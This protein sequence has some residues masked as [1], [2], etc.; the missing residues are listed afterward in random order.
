MLSSS[1]GRMTTP[2]V[3]SGP[4]D[5]IALVPTILR[6]EPEESVVVMTF[7]P[8]GRSF[9]ARVELPRRPREQ[10][11]VAET[12]LKAIK[13]NHLRE[14]AVVIYSED[15]AVAAAQGRKLNRKLRRAGVRV[16]DV[17]LVS[18][19][20]Y[21]RVLR[22][23]QE[24]TAFDISSH[25]ITA[26]R[27]LDGVV[28]H[29]SR[30]D[31]AA[32]LD[33]DPDDEARRTEVMEAAQRWARNEHDAAAEAQWIRRT[34]TDA[35]LAGEVLEDDL[36]RLLADLLDPDLVD[37]A[38]AVI[39]RPDAGAHVEMWRDLVRRAPDGY[40]D[41]PA[42]L[43]AF[44]AWLTGD[45][46]LAWCGL[47]RCGSTSLAMAD[48]LEQLMHSAVS[49]RLWPRLTADELTALRRPAA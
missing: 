29:R 25:P 44:A 31:L 40:V 19:D 47:E 36:P 3:A 34:L 6:F 33:P 17:L 32:T 39:D 43:L 42:C 22:G 26:Q 1:L 12:I 9:H 24:G 10:D 45:G 20:R 7:G 18:R 48:M 30:G 8:R 23:D 11:G 27:V 35:L 5:L 2:Y 4:E 38:W 28:V 41:A 16:A 21:F 15:R 46:A 37:V 13:S 14:C 49:P